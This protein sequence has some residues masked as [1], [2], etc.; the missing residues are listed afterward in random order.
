MTTF[1]LDDSEGPGTHVFIVGVGD[2][3]HLKDGA[4]KLTR[5][6]MGMGQLS[7]PPLSALKLLEWFDRELNNPKAPLKSIEVLISQRQ[8]ASYTDMANAT[9]E[10]E[11]ATLD[12]FISSAE[13]WFARANSDPDNVAIFYFCGHGLNDG[14]NTQLLLSDYGRDDRAMRHAINLS[15]F[16]LSMG[17]CLAK[18]QLFLI[19]ACRI[20]DPTLILDPNQLGDPGLRPG[21]ITKMNA[22]SPVIY[23]ARTGEQAFGPIDGVSY[24]AEALLQGLSKCGVHHWKGASWVVTPLHLQLAL[25]GLLDDLSGKPACPVDGL[26]GTGFEVHHLKAAPEVAVLVTLNPSASHEEAL[27]RATCSGVPHTRT[28]QEH[29]WRTFLPIGPCDV[30]AIFPAAAKFTAA[31][32]SLQ[33]H[34]PWQEIELEVT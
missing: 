16:R 19:D 18:K 31:P 12:N 27:I 13:A 17:S 2:Y 9:A 3:F 24:F 25:A 15:G 23:A 29:P 10:I 32:R 20:I 4:K 30:D 14:L 22:T 6:P 21:N 26:V 5:Q 7:S 11:G 8:A 33:L 1:H 28:N 34:P